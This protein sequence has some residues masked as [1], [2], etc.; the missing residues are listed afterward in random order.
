VDGIEA[1]EQD[2]D[3]ARVGCLRGPQHHYSVDAAHDSAAAQRERAFDAQSRLE[4]EARELGASSSG[5]GRSGVSRPKRCIARRRGWIPRGARAARESELAS[6]R[7][8]HEWRS[9][10]VR[11][12]E[13]ELAGM[14]ARLRSLEEIVTHRGGFADA[15]RHGAVNAN[16]KVGQNG[17]RGGLHRGRA[18]IRARRRGDASAICCSTSVRALEHVQP[19]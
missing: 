16:G 11:T 12:R 10:E 8:E 13:Q 5:R 17:P 4:L 19:A 1:L 14:A 9:R 15:A 18:A 6:A 2:V 7:V 3:K